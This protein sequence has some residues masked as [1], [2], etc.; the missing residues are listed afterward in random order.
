MVMHAQIGTVKPNP[1]FNFHISHISPLLKSPSIALSDPNWRV[2]M[3]DEYNAL[4]KNNTWIP[5]PTPPN[6]NVVQFMW[7]FRH[8]YHADRSLS[9]YKV[10]LVANG[11]TQQVGIDCDDT[12]SPVVKPAT[13]W[14]I[15]SL[16]LS[17]PGFCGFLF[18]ASCLS[19]TAFLIWFEAGTYYHQETK[20]AYLLIYVDDI[21]LTASSMDL[22]QRII[23]SLHKEFDMTDLGA[24]NYFLEIFVMRDST[25]MFLSQKKYALELLDKARMANCNPTRTQ[26]DTESKLSSD[27]DPISD[28]TI[29]RSLAGGLQYL[30]F[31][32]LNISYAV[33]QFCLHMHDPREPYLATLKRVLRY[34]HGKLDFGLQL[35]A[36]ITGSLV[37][38]TDVDWAAKQ[39]HTLSRSSVEAE[40]I[41]VANVV[42]KIAWL[43]NL[44]REL[45]TPLLS[46]TI[47]YCDNVR[48]LHVPSRYQ[49]ADIFTKGLP[50]ALFEEFRTS[51][52]VHPSP[53]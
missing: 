40:Y 35:Y 32:R 31:T 27:E 8:K 26:I 6:V 49:Y 20:V 22:L 12:F 37:A 50:S 18:S 30:I 39:Q 11:R 10:R 33:Q 17:P 23:S 52:S 36:S 38:Y 15:L 45:H 28:P 19:V 46:V 13:I 5:V 1:R 25:G 14:T 41:G 29:Y 24:L 53:A 51:L 7:L 9:R 47:I 34:V 4:V 2:A 44:L 3:Y 48:V 43:H 21:V 42:V 16:A